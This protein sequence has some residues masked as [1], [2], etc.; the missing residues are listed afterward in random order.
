MLLV[1]HVSVGRRQAGACKQDPALPLG[2]PDH[3][4]AAHQA[5]CRRI[6]ATAGD[7]SQGAAPE[8]VLRAQRRGQ[9]ADGH[10][11][12]ALH[13]LQPAHHMC[14]AALQPPRFAP[15]TG[16]CP[17]HGNIETYWMDQPT[18]QVSDRCLLEGGDMPSM[19]FMLSKLRRLPI[20]TLGSS[21]TAAGSLAG[22]AP[23]GCGG[24]TPS[25]LG[26]A[27]LTLAVAD[28]GLTQPPLA[29]EATSAVQATCRLLQLPLAGAC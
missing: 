2:P 22:A 25:C 5:M 9:V 1:S 17:D 29:A 10:W 3:V 23:V 18:C 6:L 27:P 20:R 15:H 14:D 7:R 11:R 4:Q 21:S 12:S 28:G 13:A 8:E 19:S 24:S 26:S 16:G